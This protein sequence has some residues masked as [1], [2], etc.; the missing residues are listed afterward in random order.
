VL[1]I[2]I[3]NCLRQ[4][5]TNKST[6]YYLYTEYYALKQ[7]WLGH[8]NIV[9]RNMRSSMAQRSVRF[10][11]RSRKLSN[12]GRSLDRWSKIYYLEFLCASEGTVSRWSW[13]QLQA[14]EPTNPHWACAVCYGPFSLWV[15]HKEGLCPGSGDINRLMMMNKKY[16]F[17]AYYLRSTIQ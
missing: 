2:F 7:T 6:K 4:L 3:V 12:V 1:V 13:M 17:L 10:G 11:V 16:S 14:L 8:S 15:I 5:T 9:I